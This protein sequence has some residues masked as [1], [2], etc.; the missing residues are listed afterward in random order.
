MTIPPVHRQCDARIRFDWGP[1]GAAA[2]VEG[3]DVAVVVDVLSFTTAVTVAV[4]NGIRVL[5]YR[6]RDAS[7]TS[8]AEA[9]DAVLALGR[10]IGERT[11]QVSL[12]PRSIAHAEGIERLVLPSPNGSTIAATLAERGAVVVAGSLRNAAA[13]A[14]W[15]APRLAGGATVAVVAGGERWP[16]DSLRPAVEDLWGAGA[17]ISGLLRGGARDASP[18]AVTAATAHDAV[19]AELSTQLAATASGRELVAAGFAADVA[20][21]AERDVT[22]VVPVLGDDGFGPAPG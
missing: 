19:A 14:A 6:W 5:P 9:R 3:A 18:E 10:S 7:A 11:G 13:V 4:E 21:A 2:I 12:S 22:S 17:V 1:V 8:Y 20:M 15:L 16:D